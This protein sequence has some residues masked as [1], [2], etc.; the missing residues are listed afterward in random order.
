MKFEALGIFLTALIMFAALP[1]AL[2]QYAGAF[3]LNVFNGST[4][5]SPFQ[6][7]INDEKEPI[8]VSVV[9]NCKDGTNDC[10]L[11]KYVNVSPTKFNLA[12][13]EVGQITVNAGVPSDYEIGKNFSGY[14]FGRKE[15]AQAGQVTIQLQVGKIIEINVV[16]KKVEQKLVEITAKGAYV[17][18]APGAVELLFGASSPF[19]A[20]VIILLLIALVAYFLGSKEPAAKKHKYKK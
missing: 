2:Q 17:P 9:L 13:G 10:D 8:V 7:V 18:E 15:T 14:M 6:W 16:E 1:M 3:A 5:S 20:F 11:L 12:P 4:N 19:L